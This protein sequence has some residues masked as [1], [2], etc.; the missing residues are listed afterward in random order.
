V[1]GSVPPATW[2]VALAVVV[3][4]VMFVVP[5]PCAAPTSKAPFRGCREHP[6]GLLGRCRHHG[7]RP[8]LRV[9]AIFGGDDL[10]QRR[11]CDKCGQSRVFLRF[12]DSGRPY[13][14]CSG[15]PRCKN[16]RSLG[17]YRF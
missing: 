17:G 13:L 16:P 6:H 4:V 15:F 9:I 8:G 2:L 12:E 5:V 7:R 3:V 14:G 1:T 10:L 11:T